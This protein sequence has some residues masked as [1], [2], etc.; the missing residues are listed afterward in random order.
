MSECVCVYVYVCGCKPN[1]IRFCLL[2]CT[3]QPLSIKIVVM[4]WNR[5]NSRRLKVGECEC[6]MHDLMHP[7]EDGSADE[8]REKMRKKQKAL[9]GMSVSAPPLC[10]FTLLNRDK[11]A[12]G[13][14]QLADV[15]EV[16][17]PLQA[18]ESPVDNREISFLSFYC[19]RSKHSP[20][21]SILQVLTSLREKQMAVHFEEEEHK[22]SREQLLS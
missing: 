16:R 13:H 22:V 3:H 2:T 15:E 1:L 20:L 18:A 12:V 5:D 10:Q 9:F 21:W 4:L 7:M 14:L 8:N 6:T 11:E 19:T 17:K